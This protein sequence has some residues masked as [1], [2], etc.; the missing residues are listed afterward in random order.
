MPFTLKRGTNISHWLSQSSRRGREREEWFTRQDIQYIADL[1][2]DHLRIP[3][4]EE[5][6]WDRTGRPVTEAFDL[7]HAALDRAESAGLRAVVDLHILRSH[8]FNDKE[9]PALYRDPAEEKK[10]CSLWSGISEQL[11]ARGTD[12]V[13]YEL[14]N[15][16]VAR[17]PGDWNR[18][19]TAAFNTIRER[20]PDRTIVLGSNSF[21]STQT[22]DVL[23]VPDD[24]HC[25]LT[26]HYYRPM[27][28]THYRAGWTDVGRYDGPVHYPG[29][30]VVSEDIAKL[31]PEVKARMREWNT[32]F[33]RS[34]MIA[35]LAGPLAVS[36]RT[37]LPLYCGEFGVINKTPMP[38]R[39]AWYRDMIRTLNDYGIAW[40][41]WDY[42]G[43]F[44]IVTPD[45]KE[46]GIAGVLLGQ[47][48]P[49]TT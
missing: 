6:M 16:A 29:R 25:I 45:G 46:T 18:V 23:H 39:L 30:P 9:E 13:A 15:E 42:K 35:D 2:F 44:G 14:L 19:S 26:Y 49:R 11:R 17:D 32:P 34:T 48:L 33:D 3:I 28:I 5:Q 36:D 24:R 21:C 47:D 10:F 7:L 31:D 1:G 8:Y 43:S 20:E 27:L 41:N 4:D 38:L 37:G 22:F 40:A 12:L